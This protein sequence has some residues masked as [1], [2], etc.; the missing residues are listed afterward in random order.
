M[1]LGFMNG[2]CYYEVKV[3]NQ[4]EYGSI[5]LG[6]MR[7]TMNM[8]NSPF[9]TNEVMYDSTPVVFMTNRAYRSTLEVPYGDFVN[10]QETVGVRTNIPS[11]SF[12][13]HIDSSRYGAI[14]IKDLGVI[15]DT[16]KNPSRFENGPIMYHPYVVL[17][18]KNDAV[19]FTS[20]YMSDYTIFFRS[21]CLHSGIEHFG[22]DD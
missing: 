18:S 12:A 9:V 2:Y 1:C 15:N 11:N 17:K 3:R 8:T 20:I 10:P 14:F 16:P 13:F 6:I 21:V 7:E 4:A 22:A 19:E 5:G